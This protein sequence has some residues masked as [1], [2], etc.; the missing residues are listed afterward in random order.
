MKILFLDSTHS[1]LEEGLV[2]AGYQLEFDYSSSVELVKKKLQDV[3]GIIIRSRFKIDRDFLESACHLKFI[4][5]F[6]AGLEN[7]DVPFAESRG[8]K[9]IRVP[10][11]NR[12]AVA[13]HAIGMLLALFNNLNRADAEIRNGIW[14]R[15]ENT[16]I[17]LQGKTVGVIGYGYM[18]SA[19]VEK[20]ESF[21]VRVLIYDKYKNQ[22]APDWAYE[23]GMRAI[24]EEADVLSLHVPL[25]KETKY[26]VN[27]DF[28][29]Q[30]RK[31]IYLINTAR[32]P[33]VDTEILARALKY[34]VVLGAC[35]DVLEYEQSSF[36]N[37]F[38]QQNFPEPLKY[39]LQAENVILSPHIAGWSHESFVKM[40]EVMLEK[41]KR[42]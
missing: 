15:A 4:G 13:E 21:D 42:I 9:C 10:E 5:R 20:L 41:I 8:I 14:N 29:H 31:P 18:G 40:A 39:L 32:G 6:G 23:T 35:L 27:R 3:D 7:I 26:M 1:V 19:F 17:E 28:L 36:E 38:T 2:A 12:N 22:F 16:G 33:I 11:G 25:T 30:F 24:F 34:K 37:L